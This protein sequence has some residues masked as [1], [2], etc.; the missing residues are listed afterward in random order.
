MLRA[1]P[2]QR[3]RGG[4]EHPLRREGDLNEKSALSLEVDLNH[5]PQRK[6]LLA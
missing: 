6:R 3:H 4:K 1:E 2:L 5:L